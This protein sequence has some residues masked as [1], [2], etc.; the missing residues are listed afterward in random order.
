MGV[1]TRSCL[2]A[3]WKQCL[4]ETVNLGTNYGLVEFDEISQLE[5][6]EHQV[7]LKLKGRK[8]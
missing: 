6:K 5:A 4:K 8:T 3:P 1:V 2:R 7:R